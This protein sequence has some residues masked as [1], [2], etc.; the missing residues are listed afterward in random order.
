[1]KKKVLYVAAALLAVCIA[2]AGGISAFGEAAKNTAPAAVVNAVISDHA[3]EAVQEA[4][5]EGKDVVVVDFDLTG[6]FKNEADGDGYKIYE[7]GTFTAYRDFENKKGK[8]IGTV[9]PDGD[10]WVFTSPGLDKGQVYGTYN[11]PIPLLPSK[12]CRCISEA[13]MPTIKA[14]LSGAKRWKT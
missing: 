5:E 9:L 12:W 10:K 7:D 8:M 1:M 2:G 11:I 4:E 14:S 6:S 3:N 13:C